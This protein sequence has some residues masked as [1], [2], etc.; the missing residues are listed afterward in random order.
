MAT[1]VFESFHGTHIITYLGAGKKFSDRLLGSAL[2][3]P[4]ILDKK[5]YNRDRPH[6]FLLGIT[7]LA[8]Y[9]NYFPCR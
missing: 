6:R 7:L 1:V 5:R 3:W 8:R 4:T 2:S 9:I